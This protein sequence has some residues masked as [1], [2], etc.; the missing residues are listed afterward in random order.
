MTSSAGSAA[1]GTVEVVRSGGWWM[2]LQ[3]LGIL[4]VVLAA[5]GFAFKWL[6]KAGFGRSFGGSTAAVQ[7]LSRGYLTNK[8]QMVLVRFGGRVLLLGVGPQNLNLLSEVSDPAEVAQVLARLE[9]GKPGS[10]SQEFQQTID[11]AVQEYDRKGDAV[12][13]GG[14]PP[15]T[16]ASEPQIGA[17]R[18][19]LRGL[20]AKM[21]SISRKSAE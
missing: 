3:T 14:E 10:I 16:S 11:S 18:Q 4:A 6:R 15:A 2:W 21:Q 7:V 8:H 20:L 13:G 5:M 19:E 1:E 9:G 17:L 12:A